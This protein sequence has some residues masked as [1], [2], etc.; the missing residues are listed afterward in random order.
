MK[1]R[2]AARAASV[3]L[4][5][6]VSF[7]PAAFAIRAAEAAR[8]SAHARQRAR[9]APK[10]A[11]EVK[12]FLVALEDDGR[13]GRRIGCG[14]SLVPVTRTVNA[15]G[16]ATLR[17]AVEELLSVPHDY[18]ARLKNFWRGNDLRL[19]GVTL[20]NGL[21]TIRIT[22]EGPFIAG[23]CDAPRI[24]EQIRATARQFPTVRRVA[25]FVNG[26]SLES[27]LR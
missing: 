18:D 19:S 16:G 2:S 23:V 7:A 20:R 9:A 17:A 27:A 21:A 5:G 22:G 4:C 14:D 10:A 12:V 6:F 26:R 3:L 11:R 24:A 25:V 8:V 15:P 1:R 13:T